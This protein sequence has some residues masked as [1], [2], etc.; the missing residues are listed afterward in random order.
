MRRRSCRPI[1]A[2]SSG[3]D[4][5]QTSP[6]SASTHIATHVGEGSMASSSLRL[7]FVTGS[8]AHG[9]AERQTVALMNRLAERGHEC[10]VA[11]VKCDA[12]LV[13]LI[14]VREAGSVSAL[15]AL[16]YLDVRA[17]HTLAGPIARLAPSAA[18]AAS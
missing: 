5:R 12:E 14:R 11:Y 3:R 17:L 8:L 13:D 2:S 16:R 15:G 7:L 10:H 6:A 1:D 18:V 9:G 4:C